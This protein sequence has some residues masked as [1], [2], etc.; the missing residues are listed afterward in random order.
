MA[1]SFYSKLRP[2]AFRRRIPNEEEGEPATSDQADNIIVVNLPGDGPQNHQFEEISGGD[3]SRYINGTYNDQRS[4][5]QQASDPPKESYLP[6]LVTIFGI[7]L[8]TVLVYW[9]HRA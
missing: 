9:A 6:V 8:F 2:F 7:S 1:N 5:I 4:R 3:N